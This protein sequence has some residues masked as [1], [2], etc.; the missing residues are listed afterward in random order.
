MPEAAAAAAEDSR[1]AVVEPST[2]EEASCVRF[3]ASGRRI[4]WPGGSEMTLPM[5]KAV[6]FPVGATAAALCGKDEPDNRQEARDRDSEVDNEKPRRVFSM[7]TSP[8]EQKGSAESALPPPR[9]E[10]LRFRG[11]DCTDVLGD[12]LFPASATLLFC[13]GTT[14]ATEDGKSF[15]Y[16]SLNIIIL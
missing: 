1:P 2:V 8:D 13:F 16:P 14:P 5:C 15:C 10:V 7:R 4:Y 3:L 9:A 12:R 11:T 6:A